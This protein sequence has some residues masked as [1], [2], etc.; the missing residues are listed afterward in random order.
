[1]GIL[2]RF[3]E[4]IQANVNA[5]L[6]KMED[7]S[8]MIDQY[9]RELSDNL[10]E[11]KRETAGVMAEEARTKRLVDANQAEISKYEE[12]AK[13]ALR[14]GNEGDAKVF[15][16]KKQQLESSGAGLQTAYAAAHENAVKM[17]QMHDKLVA[18]IET[19]KSRRATIKAKVSV[20]KTQERLNKISSAS[21]KANGAMSAFDRMEDKAN[22]MLDE[23]NAMAELNTEP[24][25][26]A[27]AL[28][29]K[30]RA[31]AS[32]AS[33]DAELEALK[34]SMGL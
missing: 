17:R 22:R 1:M 25:D 11:V 30:Y 14:A 10:A 23:A 34:K 19:L 8:K 21:D 16:A 29:E 33:V 20:A 13:Q 32:D 15:L 2:S 4:I 18:D 7:P 28:E 9:L 27:K 26:E 31:G 6:D 3:S 5:V 12:L 24:V